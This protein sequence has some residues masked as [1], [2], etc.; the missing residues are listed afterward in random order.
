MHFSITVSNNTFTSAKESKSEKGVSKGY[1][2]NEFHEKKKMKTAN[3]IDENIP[4]IL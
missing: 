3:K 4:S 2:S 1:D